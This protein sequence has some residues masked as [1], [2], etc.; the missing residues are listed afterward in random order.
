MHVGIFTLHDM[1]V[2]DGSWLRIVGPAQYLQ[3]LG[4][5]VTLFA[6]TFPSALEGK[7]D[8]VHVRGQ[9]GNPE[10]FRRLLLLQASYGPLL[11]LSKRLPFY[12]GLARTLS[13][14][15]LDLI[16]C[17]GHSG[18]L[19][20][21]RMLHKLK[22][23]VAFDVHGIYRLQFPQGGGPRQ[24]LARHLTLRAE[25]RLFTCMDALV[26]ES[27][28][29]REFLS[30]EYGIVPERI[31]LAPSGADVDFL[32]KP[33]DGNEK[34]GLRKELGLGNERVVLFAGAFKPQSGVTVLI[35]AFRIVNAE[36]P[37]V[38]LVL[39]GDPADM[40][41]EDNAFL[42]RTNLSNVILAGR[43]SRERFR[44]FQQ[45]SDVV[46]VPDADTAFT[47]LYAPLKLYDALSSGRPAVVTRVPS[48]AEMIQDGVNGY[49][50]NPD[51]PADMARGIERALDDPNSAEV[52]RRAQ[53]MMIEKHSWRM[54]ARL[55][56]QGYDTVVAPPAV[57]H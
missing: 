36:R 4:C 18:G 30:R 22:A 34:Q 10:P 41:D 33:V 42:R 43:Q 11:A 35:R 15:D 53:Q 27:M 32:C 51:D 6:P 23:P 44:T 29:E 16:H 50:V 54:A 38:R 3:E 24:R 47:R 46:A 19:L 21:L 26:I 8:F 2:A 37:N 31:L 25:R 57:I 7:S 52:G 14:R 56:V 20:L 9:P 45:I 49:L 39:I 48:R 17:H 5:K 55:L 1:N 13:E 28:V 40:S 12:P